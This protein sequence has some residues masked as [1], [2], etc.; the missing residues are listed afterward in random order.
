MRTFFLVLA[1]VLSVG[2][3]RPV[4]GQT[5]R[6]NDP[7]TVTDT[8]QIN[9]K[10]FGSAIVKDASGDLERAELLL[11]W[12]S[13]HFKWLSTDYK[14]RTVKEII[15]RQGGNCFELATVYSS[16]IKTMG[17]RHRQIAEI[18]IQPRSERRQ[19]S[20][21]EL[22]AK[23]GNY[24][25]VF[26]EQHNDHRWIEI[27]DSKSAD[28]I[29]ADPSVGVIG[30]ESWLKSRVWFGERWAIDT[31]ITN[32]MIVPIAIFVADGKSGMVEDRSTH[33][34]IT[35]FDNLYGGALSRLASWAEWKKEVAGIGT[36]CRGAFEGTVNLHAHADEIAQLAR[37]YAALRA[38][39]ENSQK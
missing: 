38:E 39:W 23:R 29:P 2:A 25:S 21:E 32:D 36:L 3:W 11:Q 15:A 14:N 8:A 4:K 22:M 37:T 30:V 9:L 17:I 1:I 18:N 20:A 12:L 34:L 19:K 16:L 13:Q 7:L 6:G 35:A 27:F 31:S 26:G 10:D 5:S 28:W 24:G 33:Y